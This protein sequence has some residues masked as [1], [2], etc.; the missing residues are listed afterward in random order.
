[1]RNVLTVE[2]ENLL[3]WDFRMM[4]GVGS[5]TWLVELDTELSTYGSRKVRH[6]GNMVALTIS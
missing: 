4:D 3:I 6:F 5:L 2:T 1:M